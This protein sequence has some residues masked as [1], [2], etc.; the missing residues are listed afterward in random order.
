MQSGRTS[1]AIITSQVRLRAWE[2]IPLRYKKLPARRLAAEG[3]DLLF[4]ILYITNKTDGVTVVQRRIII[5]P[6]VYIPVIIEPEIITR[7]VGVPR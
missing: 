7:T 4:W 3:I 2:V 6:G 1:C 5:T